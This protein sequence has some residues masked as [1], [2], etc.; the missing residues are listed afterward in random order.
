MIPIA[1][2]PEMPETPAQPIEPARAERP[3]YPQDRSEDKTDKTDPDESRTDSDEKITT[4][5]YDIAEKATTLKDVW[6][7]HQ[8]EKE[9]AAPADQAR[10]ELD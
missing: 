3:V 9:I 7:E 1:Q 6:K 10:D 5:V 8:G 4:L 2:A